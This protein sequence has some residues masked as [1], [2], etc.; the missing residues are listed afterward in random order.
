M[1]F[2]YRP[3]TTGRYVIEAK[4]PSGQWRAIQG[5]EDP[6]AAAHFLDWYRQHHGEGSVTGQV[7][8]IET[9]LNDT[10]SDLP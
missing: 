5:C 3:T 1:G 2:A 7:L 10:L 9:R 8:G 4:G 6:D